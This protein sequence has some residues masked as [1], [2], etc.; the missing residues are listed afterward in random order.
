MAT[1]L[2]K[3][4]LFGLKVEGT[5]GTAVQLTIGDARE[6]KGGGSIG[7]PATKEY[8][9]DALTPSPT[10][11]WPVENV[12]EITVPMDFRY[13]GHELEIAVGM[14]GATAPAVQTNIKAFVNEFVFATLA[15]AMTGCGAKG[16]GKSGAG[17]IVEVA[18]V[19]GL[20]VKTWKL[21]QDQGRLTQEFELIGI[22]PVYNTTAG[23]NTT[24]TI[25]VITMPDSAYPTNLARFTHLTAWL[26]HQDQ[27]SFS[28]ADAICIE[29]YE[30]SIEFGITDSVDD[31]RCTDG[32]QVSVDANQRMIE[33]TLKFLRDNSATKTV[34]D[35]IRD[36]EYLKCK[37]IYASDK[38]IPGTV[39]S[40]TTPLETLAG[41]G[42]DPDIGVDFTL[43]LPSGATVNESQNIVLNVSY[44]S[45]AAIAAGIQA[46]VRAA[47]AADVRLQRIYDN[48][49]CDWDTTVAGTYFCTIGTSDLLTFDIIAG[50]G[51]DCAAT[52]KLS[53]AG[54]GVDIAHLPLGIKKFFPQL[55][56]TPPEDSYDSGVMKK[57]LVGRALIG[58]VAAPI[59]F[60]MAEDD[61][62]QSD[63]DSEDFRICIL[64]RNPAAPI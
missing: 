35:L 34:Y 19:A 24:A 46:Q 18:E 50:T 1:A 8:N 43:T 54:S 41:A 3:H 61:W 25:L 37:L 47:T 60:N 30:L 26:A 13:H 7:A 59:G 28:S 52:L 49:T 9:E 14:G 29:G 2:G 44:T 56:F 10:Q 63:M 40:D 32:M 39:T 17:D 6:I 57:E 62:L 55:D 64:N 5:P 21:S 15:D 11:S 16:E 45:G 31:N 48:F 4:T 27:G 23:T 12:G 38:G 58:P 33:L 36:Y 53:A 20:R 51:N 22:L 42:A